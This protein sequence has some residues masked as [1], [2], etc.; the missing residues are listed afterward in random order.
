[1]FCVDVCVDLWVYICACVRARPPPATN[2]HHHHKTHTHTHH[3]FKTQNKTK[4]THFKKK[5]THTHTQKQVL[6]C[7]LEPALAAASQEILSQKTKV[8][9]KDVRR[10]DLEVP[11]QVRRE[12][13]SEGFLCV[14][15]CLSVWVCERACVFI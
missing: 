4:N 14:C 2:Y 1:V 10:L 9:T 15:V 8:F 3:P 7:E 12:R 5:H 6:G 13:L 11:P